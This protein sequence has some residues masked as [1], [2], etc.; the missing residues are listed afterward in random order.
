VAITVNFN[1]KVDEKAVH[2]RL[3]KATANDLKDTKALAKELL[4]GTEKTIVGRLS[5]T[6]GKLGRSLLIGLPDVSFA[7]V[8]HRTINW[9]ILK[10]VKYVVQ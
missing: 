10:N 5:K 2:E 1:C 7:Q 9:V 6:E 4:T 8:D 3:S